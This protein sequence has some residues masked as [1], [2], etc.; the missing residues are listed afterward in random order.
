V[1][2]ANTFIINLIS[3]QKWILTLDPLILFYCLYFCV[4]YRNQDVYDFLV[5]LIK[6]LNLTELN[7]KKVN[8]RK[9]MNDLRSNKTSIKNEFDKSHQI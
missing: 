2:A 3:S 4:Y 6:S 5:P 8:E 9:K 1:N 7:E